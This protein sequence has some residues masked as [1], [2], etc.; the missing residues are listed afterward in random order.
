MKNWLFQGM[1]TAAIAVP[2]LSGAA[3][4]G[5]ADDYGCSN[6]TLNGKPPSWRGSRCRWQADPVDIADRL[7][8]NSAPPIGPPRRR[9]PAGN[10]AQQ[11]AMDAAPQGE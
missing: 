3:R 4:A 10:L 9:R 1:L 8:A 11:I 6:A 2:A 7:S 5:G